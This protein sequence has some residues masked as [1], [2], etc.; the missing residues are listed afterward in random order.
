M[1]ANL[2]IFL[3]AKPSDEMTFAIA[4]Q[5]GLMLVFCIGPLIVI[6]LWIGRFGRPKRDVRINP[7]LGQNFLG[8]LDIFGNFGQRSG[9]FLDQSGLGTLQPQQQPTETFAHGWHATA[10]PAALLRVRT[11]REAGERNFA[12]G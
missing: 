10:Y 2:M 6:T 8:D 5:I 7:N 4:A 1:L 3:G 12:T 9:L 11:G